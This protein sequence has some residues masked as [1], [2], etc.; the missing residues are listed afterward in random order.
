MWSMER[1]DNNIMGEN[2]SCCDNNVMV[3]ASAKAAVDFD[4]TQLVFPPFDEMTVFQLLFPVFGAL[5]CRQFK[6]KGFV[7]SIAVLLFAAVLSIDF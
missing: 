5:D 6:Q 4:A 2:E 1:L 3:I 7:R